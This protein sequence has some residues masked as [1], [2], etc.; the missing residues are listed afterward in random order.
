MLRTQAS[1]AVE[2]NLPIVIHSRDSEHDV[3]EELEK[4]CDNA[5][6]V[7]PTAQCLCVGVCHKSVFY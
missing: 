5:S 1:L 7:Y 2:L 3:I 4:V 6:V